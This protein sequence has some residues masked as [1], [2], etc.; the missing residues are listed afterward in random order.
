MVWFDPAI[1]SSDLSE[2]PC[3]LGVKQLSGAL[4]A[5][6]AKKDAE[7]AERRFKNKIT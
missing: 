3:A 5:E 4:N 6:N 2:S 7:L 1:C